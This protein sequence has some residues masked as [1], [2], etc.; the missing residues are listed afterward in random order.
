MGSTQNQ[1]PLSDMS[2]F[3]IKVFSETGNRFRCWVVKASS[4]DDAMQ[5]AFALDG[6]WG[7]DKDASGMLALAQ[8]Y[9]EVIAANP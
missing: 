3:T 6:G 4:P 9:C 2:E 7:K 5:L 1:S 8:T